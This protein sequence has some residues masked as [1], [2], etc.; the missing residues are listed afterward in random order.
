VQ[1][2]KYS[3]H[4]RHERRCARLLWSPYSLSWS[5]QRQC[6]W[7]RAGSTYM[8]AIFFRVPCSRRGMKAAVTSWTPTTFVARCS[9]RS[10]LQIVRYTLHKLART[11]EVGSNI[12]V[13]PP[14]GVH[15]KIPALF[16]RTSSPLPSSIRSTSLAAFSMLSSLVVSSATK[17]T[18]PPDLAMRS[19]R[20]LDSWREVAKMT[21]TSEAGREASWVARE[22]PM[23]REQPVIR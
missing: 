9:W 1:L 18:L 7:T 22:R 5:Y 3:M 16:I 19:L 10:I 12:F 13:M 8:L 2:S 15:L 11:G 4:E 23:P 21:L 20:A 14:A 17:M 6:S